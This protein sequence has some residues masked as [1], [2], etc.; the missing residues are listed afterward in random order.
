MVKM[1]FFIEPKPIVADYESTITVTLTRTPAEDIS[2]IQNVPVVVTENGTLIGSASTD[3]FGSVTF[4]YKFTL[5]AGATKKTVFVKAVASTTPILTKTKMIDVFAPDRSEGLRTVYL[6]PKYPTYDE[7]VSK[8]VS[9]N[10]ARLTPEQRNS[11]TNTFGV[12]PEVK[13][14]EW[15]R[16]TMTAGMYSD[17]ISASFP[18][19]IDRT[20]EFSPRGLTADEILYLKKNGIP[21][22][23]I[24]SLDK[25]ATDGLLKRIVSRKKSR[26]YS[27][28]SSCGFLCTV[29]VRISVSVIALA[30]LY[31]LG[32]GIIDLIKGRLGDAKEWV[33]NFLLNITFKND[34]VEQSKEYTITPAAKRERVMGVYDTRLREWDDRARPDV[35]NRYTTPAGVTLPVMVKHQHITIADGRAPILDQYKEK[36]DTGNLHGIIVMYVD[37]DGKPKEQGFDIKFHKNSYE[38]QLKRAEY[39]DKTRSGSQFNLGNLVIIERS[40]AAEPKSITLEYKIAPKEGKVSRPDRPYNKEETVWESPPLPDP[41]ATGEEVKLYQITGGIG[42]EAKDEAGFKIVIDFLVDY[43]RHY[44]DLVRKDITTDLSKLTSWATKFSPQISTDW[45]TE[46]LP[47][48]TVT[49]T[50]TRNTDWFRVKFDVPAATGFYAVAAYGLPIN[51]LIYTVYAQPIVLAV[52]DEFQWAEIISIIDQIRNT[53][54]YTIDIKIQGKTKDVVGNYTVSAGEKLNITGT[55]KDKDGKPVGAGVPVTILI[56]GTEIAE[57]TGVGWKTDANGQVKLEH[58]F[59]SIT[60]PP[61]HNLTMKAEPI[62]ETPIFGT[63]FIYVDTD[64]TLHFRDVAATISL[65]QE[66]RSGYD[67]CTVNGK[68]V[69]GLITEEGKEGVKVDLRVKADDVAV[70]KF[71]TETTTAADGSFG[72]DFAPTFSNLG[73]TETDQ[74]RAGKPVKI[75]ITV[76]TERGSQELIFGSTIK[77]FLYAY[78]AEKFLCSYAIIPTYFN[79]WDELVLKCTPGYV[80]PPPTWWEQYKWW[81]VGGAV[82]AGVVGGILAFLYYQKKKR[83]KER[84]H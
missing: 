22:A 53:L 38:F 43:F 71:W 57:P 4:P 78:D 5:P 36:F 35:G 33:D 1:L 27:K 46:Y 84:G 62:P 69:S 79:T 65:M 29:I 16:G 14:D 42:E 74:H 39:P 13:M 77:V 25:N 58:T 55:V 24:S 83:E 10:V 45:Q 26:N 23:D 56:D 19:A 11:I 15:V 44:F 21:D 8:A 20:M 76:V 34:M 63:V 60:F 61:L 54:G 47:T 75:E 52:V 51:D 73:I 70:T 66:G 17:F 68:L 6:Y 37:E 59:E 64:R 28:S 2:L 67:H 80:P 12:A 30:V 72:I 3:Q 48:R 18:A 7:A 49:G 81:V 41:V 40:T 50:V 31:K 82:T 32:E 9:E